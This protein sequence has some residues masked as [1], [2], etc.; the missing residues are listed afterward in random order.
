MVKYLYAFLIIFIVL[1]CQPEKNK[2][3][4]PEPHLELGQK[5]TFVGGNAESDYVIVGYK[6]DYS[7]EIEKLW[8][9]QDY[10]V[11][12]YTNAQNDIKEGT[13]HVNSVVKK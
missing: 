9:D 1:A 5:V 10:I 8:K 7:G 6:S 3:A 12:I 11:F 13:V 2:T 4:V